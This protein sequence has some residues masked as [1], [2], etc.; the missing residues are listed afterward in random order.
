MVNTERVIFAG[1][2]LLACGSVL[3][4]AP[5]AGM[6]KTMLGEVRIERAGEVLMPKVGDAIM[7]RDRIV[8]GRNS[9]I[10]FTLKDDTL[11]SAGANS[12]FVLEDFA[13][14]PVTR[15]GRLDASLVRGMM[16]F[17]SGAL[18]GTSPQNVAVR[19]GTATIGIRG[20]DFIVE[21]DDA[22]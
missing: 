7:A 16:R 6:V 17:V 3:A 21:V 18:A 2:L 19:T 8:T 15:S 9:S 10:G 22:W 13:F 4:E 1:L 5:A 12:N 20:T 11:I 14:N